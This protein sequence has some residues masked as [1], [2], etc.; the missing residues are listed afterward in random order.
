LVRR[1]PAGPTKIN[2]LLAEDDEALPGA[3]L[4]TCL[5]GC[6]SFFLAALKKNYDESFTINNNRILQKLIFFV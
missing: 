3:A 4:L 5:T 6:C 2:T 1:L